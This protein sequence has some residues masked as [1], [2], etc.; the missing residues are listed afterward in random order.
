ML[1]FD[2]ETD[3]AQL[4]RAGA[5]GIAIGGIAE[6]YQIR[7]LGETALP[8]LCAAS[9]AWREQRRP[10]PRKLLFRAAEGQDMR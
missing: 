2:E 10:L 4:K 7:R 5:A 8:L 3:V 6:N 1:A 9:P